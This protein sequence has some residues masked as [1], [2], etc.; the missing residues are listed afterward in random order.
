MIEKA[1]N[2]RLTKYRLVYGK[3]VVHWLVARTEK[4]GILTI[5][6]EAHVES[7]NIDIRVSETTAVNKTFDRIN[8]PRKR[9]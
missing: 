6:R 3:Y 1:R 4:S 8:N 7:Y 5:F 2:K 9:W